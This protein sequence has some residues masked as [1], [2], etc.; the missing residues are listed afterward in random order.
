MFKYFCELFL[1][2]KEVWMAEKCK[3]ENHKSGKVS[4][5]SFIRSDIM[6]LY[7]VKR[8][9]PIYFHKRDAFLLYIALH[10]VFLHC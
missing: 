3:G 5:V 1:P 4:P 9:K 7:F 2:S 8:E 10:V 6:C